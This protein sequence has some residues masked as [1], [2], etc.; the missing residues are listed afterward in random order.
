MDALRNPDVRRFADEQAA[1]LRGLATEVRGSVSRTLVVSHGMIMELALLASIGWEE[2]PDAIEV[3]G[4]CEGFVL[5]YDR[6]ACTLQEIKRLPIGQR[7]I[8]V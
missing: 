7:L 2:L 8:D 1:M 4:Y 6:S 3:F 5:I